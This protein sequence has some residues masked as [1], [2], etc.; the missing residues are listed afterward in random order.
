MSA[1]ESLTPAPLTVNARQLPEAAAN[2]TRT[3]S[4]AEEGWDR[5]ELLRSRSAAR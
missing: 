5:E 1:S 4:A 3:G 2:L